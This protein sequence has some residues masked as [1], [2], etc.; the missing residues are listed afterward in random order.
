MPVIDYPAGG[1]AVEFVRTIDALLQLDFDTLIPGHGRLMS[2]DEVL[3]YKLRFEEMNQRMAD[4]ARR[5]VP[6]AD[7][8]ARLRLEELGWSNTVSTTTWA[9]GIDAYYDEM[10]ALAR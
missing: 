1:S 5:G 3:A 8:Q 7:A 9:A 4:L 10:A 6:K 2:K